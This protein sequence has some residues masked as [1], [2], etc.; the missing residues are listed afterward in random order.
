MVKKNSIYNLDNEN[1][2]TKNWTKEKIGVY[3]WTVLHLIV[4]RLPSKLTKDE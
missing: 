3:G 1:N 4:A 2:S